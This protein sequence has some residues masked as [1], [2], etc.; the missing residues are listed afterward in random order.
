M[1]A[2]GAMRCAP[3][4]GG[5]A[6]QQHACMSLLWECTRTCLCWFVR[7]DHPPLR[8]T[9]RHVEEGRGQKKG[10]PVTLV[11]CHVTMYWLWW[12]GLDWTS[13]VLL[14]RIA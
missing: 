6:C 1:H 8:C 4:C 14:S 5:G 10:A 3:A 13:M 7:A 2:D 12:T 11:M 9:G